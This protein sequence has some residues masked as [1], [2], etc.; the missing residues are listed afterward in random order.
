MQKKI[1]SWPANLPMPIEV[2]T[3]PERFHLLPKDLDSQEAIQDLAD[4]L[5]WYS[6]DLYYLFHSENEHLT[7]EAAE[8]FESVGIVFKTTESFFYLHPKPRYERE[9]VRV[10]SEEEVI[11][12]AYRRTTLSLNPQVRKER[13]F[14]ETAIRT[15]K[16]LEAD[17]PI[18]DIKPNIHG[19]G[20]N[21]NE[22]FRRLKFW[23][24]SKKF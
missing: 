3:L 19:V 16:A 17:E 6:Q 18:L 5:Y 4:E 21:F 10:Y 11:G 2:T 8:I 12:K 1:P 23:Y 7:Q 15:K 13:D 24:R 9:F 22:V 14:N 20:V